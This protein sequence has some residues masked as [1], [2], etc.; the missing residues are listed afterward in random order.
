M[1]KRLAKAD[2]HTTL[3]TDEWAVAEDPISQSFDELVEIEANTTEDRAA[4]DVLDELDECGTGGRIEQTHAAECFA[5]IIDW[6]AEARGPFFLWCH[7]TGLGGPWDAPYEFR[8]RYAEEDDPRPPMTVRPPVL[9]LEE[10]YDPDTLLGITQSYAGQVSLFDTCIGAL[11]EFLAE[12]GLIDD[13]LLAITSPRGYPLGE[14]RRVGPCDEALFGET[15]HVPLLIR[16]PDALAAAARSQALAMPADLGPT[17]LDWLGLGKDN[18][19]DTARS[20]LPIAR[21]DVEAV[22]DRIC[23]AGVDG[24]RAIRTPAW[25][26]RMEDGDSLFV[27]PDD[28]WEFNDVAERCPHVVDL[29]CK[30]ADEFQSHVQAGEPT[31]LSPLD[32]VLI[33]GLE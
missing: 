16:F 17:L 20:L 29:L 26:Q 22:R 15:L 6:I 25:F 23:A 4:G 2:I 31:D 18:L 14:H 27:K 13:T 7:L 19:F 24:G 30:A 1:L 32:D 3:L 28:R 11:N 33:E 5:R 21:G 9:R 12:N 10:D 8:L